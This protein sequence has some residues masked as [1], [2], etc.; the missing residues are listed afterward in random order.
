MNLDNLHFEV[1]R[2]ASKLLSAAGLTPEQAVSRAWKRLR[3]SPAEENG[4]RFGVFKIAGVPMRIVIGPHRDFENGIA[5]V[6]TQAEED[7][8]LHAIF[9]VGQTPG[10][11][12][13]DN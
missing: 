1:S 4:V 8:F 12:P 2:K 3:N 10:P 7:E 5:T 11:E 9:D 13:S 6:R